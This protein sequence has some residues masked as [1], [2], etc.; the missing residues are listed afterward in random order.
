VKAITGLV[1]QDSLASVI[2]LLIPGL[3][4]A[5]PVA[6]SVLDRF[7]SAADLAGRHEAVAVTIFGF[8]VL[9]FGLLCDV[10]RSRV[11]W[12]YF[13][14][15]VDSRAKDH[16]S[17]WALFLRM[18]YEVEPIGHRYIRRMLA[19]MKFEFCTGFGLLISWSGWEV[20]FFGRI[21]LTLGPHLG[22]ASIAISVGFWL[23]WES[24]ETHELLSQTRRRLVRDGVI[25]VHQH[26][27]SV[28]CASTADCGRSTGDED[29]DTAAN[30]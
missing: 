27:A 11:E 17:N 26:G 8:S 29:T 21:P 20:L 18:A 25:F 16:N 6:A 24:I 9:F 2:S 30:D 1:S 13:D 4:V 19:T 14:P 15:R 28:S 10:V 12:A 3:F 5:S 23:I 7:P 22:L